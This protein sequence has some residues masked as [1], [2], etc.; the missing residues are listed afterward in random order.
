MKKPALPLLRFLVRAGIAVLAV[1]SLTP[2]AGASSIYTDLPSHFALQWLIGAGVML[3]LAGLLRAG[4]GFM[5]LA[6]V[7]AGLN[8][9]TLAPYVPRGSTA[10]DAAGLKILQ[11]NTLFLHRDTDALRRLVMAEN[12][13]IIALSEVNDSFA[14]LL[15]DLSADY[16]YRHIH[17]RDNSPRG[18]ALLSRYPLHNVA[19]RTFSD[20]RIPALMAEL[21]YQG[22]RID[23]LSIH[24]MTPVNNIKSRDGDFAAMADML[25]PR[26]NPRIIIGDFNATPWSPAL[27]SF[28]R[29]LDVKNARE[30][31]GYLGTWPAAFPAGFL[32]IPIDHVFVSRDIGVAEMRVAT[33]IGSDH[34]PVI[35]VLTVDAR[36]ADKGESPDE[37]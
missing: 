3:G 5:L 27:R 28:A 13:D 8:A 9:A 4:R 1:F 23:L 33:S 30:G 16:P 2:Y 11:A 17:P 36:P 22:R 26:K 31:A 14:A 12:P 35:A 29:R 34:L 15:H 21:S 7:A 37:N 18:L 24:P 10:P 32:R 20:A 19:H 25:E 6:A